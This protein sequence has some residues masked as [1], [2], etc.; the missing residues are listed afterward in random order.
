[1][2]LDTRSALDNILSRRRTR[3]SR[4]AIRATRLH[5]LLREELERKLRGLALG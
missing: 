3:L 2:T 1:M 4:E 5:S